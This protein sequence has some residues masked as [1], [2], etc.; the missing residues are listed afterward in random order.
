MFRIDLPCDLR[1]EISLKEALCGFSFEIKYINGKTYTLNNSVG[2]II[3]S[4]HQKI[5]QGLGLKRESHVGNLIVILRV[6]FPEKLS[7]DQI[8]K[9]K[10][11]L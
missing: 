10:Q 11:I 7:E 5:I 1:K 8:Q 6:K 9:L 3:Q 4:E 2:N